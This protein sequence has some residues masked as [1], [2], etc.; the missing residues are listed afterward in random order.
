M[1]SIYYQNIQSIYNKTD[2]ITLCLEESAHSIELLAFTEHWLDNNKEPLVNIKN[3]HMASNF[4]R[5]SSEC[6][7]SCIFVRNN[8]L[9]K[10]LYHLKQKSLESEIECSAVEIMSL[11]MKVINIYRPPSGNFDSFIH[12][13]ED[14]LISA[15]KLNTYTIVLCGDFNLDLQN[16]N[17][18]KVKLFLD[19][20]A[21]F[22]LRP[23]I[24]APTRISA[25][26]S[27]TIDNIFINTL[28]YESRVIKNGLSDH[29]GIGI[30][31][32]TD[33]KQKN[34]NNKL[35]CRII[36][37]EKLQQ[38][39]VMISELNWNQII[40][41]ENPNLSASK[42]I[43]QFVQILDVIYPKKLHNRKAP[44]NVWINE[45]LRTRSRIKR[46]LYEGMLE[47]YVTDETYKQYKVDLK[48]RI[49]EAKKCAHSTY[50]LNSNNK[51]KA[52][53]ELVKDITG[54]N[55]QCSDFDIENIRKGDNQKS[56]KE[57]LDE[58]N[59]YYINICDNVNKNLNNN[60]KH[61]FRNTHSMVLDETTPVEIYNIINSLKDT[62]AVGAD[63]VPTKL[64][65]YCA[66]EICEPLSQIVNMCFRLGIFPDDLKR[67]VIKP[68]HKKGDKN[69]ISN[70]RP[71]ALISII[72]KIFEKAL[73]S[74]IIDFTEKYSIISDMQSAYIKGRSTVR[75]IYMGICEILD[76]I[77]KKDKAAALFLDLSKAFDSV[78]HKCLL[79]KLEIMGF[80]GNIHNILKS[81]LEDRKQCIVAIDDGYYISSDW[82]FVK[83]GV[84]QGSILGPILF[85]LYINDLPKVVKHL[86]NLFADDNSLVIRAETNEELETE[87][88]MSIE[89]LNDWYT[90][91]NLKLNI[92]KTN[93]LKFSLRKEPPLVVN[94][95]NESLTSTDC[96]KFLGI[97]I[98]SQLNWKDH[99]EYLAPK[100]S[101]FIYALRTISRSV[102]EEAA[103][104]SYYAY[105]K[106][107]ITYGV[108]FWGNSVEADRI[109]R[110]QKACLRSIFHLK[111]TETCSVIFKEKHILTLPCIYIYE[112]A[113]L[114]KNNYNDFFNKYKVDH[115]YDT[116]NNLLRMPKTSFSHVQRNVESQLIKIYNNL[117]NSYKD[118]PVTTFKKTL[119][120]FLTTNAFYSISEFLN[121]K[122]QL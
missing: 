107:R 108:V 100:I 15:T 33:Y 111:K 8:I 11:Y 12:V 18:N 54:K 46:Q 47:G 74:R 65:K 69:D 1:F 63:Q 116:R 2:E 99:I 60:L 50:I 34:V 73:L 30:R 78:D 66:E 121:Y 55:K 93:L 43:K 79:E 86:V 29:F 27:T 90:S 25:T 56:K 19:M 31:I 119:H 81:Y 20:L 70:Y 28:D 14:I 104:T 52:T 51:V 59:D 113:Y 82:K 97:M 39:K 122:F 4:I 42:F 22:D 68:L 98:D 115:L 58:V 112:C 21:T 35:E 109:F 57:I 9:F 38:F 7:G 80:R 91:N 23:S 117:P 26:S 44:M 62:A 41:E 13:L 24:Q 64:L 89:T 85:L 105:I 120:N 10:E 45:D 36:C 92:D 76:A 71:I 83:T 75:A 37:D 17:D 48:M 118:L 87:I 102:S 32:P 84:P 61:V 40:I 77:S 49:S 53:W 5:Q 101:S 16:K 67:T 110:L 103:M 106:S 95:N 72:S 3:Y 96:T 6:G 88:S 114:V 94:L